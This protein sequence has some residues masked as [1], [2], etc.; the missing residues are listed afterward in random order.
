MKKALV[1]AGGGSK[2]A[3]QLGAWKALEELGERFQIA[4]GTSIGS[5]NA[6]FYVQ[7]DFAAAE[8]KLRNPEKWIVSGGFL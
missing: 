4:T 5:I 6:A 2:G 8:K 1:F 3:Y 7:H